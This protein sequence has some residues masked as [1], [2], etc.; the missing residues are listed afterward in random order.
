MA[1]ENNKE[2]Q[3]KPEQSKQEQSK[4]EQSK[5]ERKDS[6]EKS[7]K[8]YL[9]W[10][11]LALI[12]VS[13]AGAGF[14][15]GRLFGRSGADDA[16]TTTQQTEGPQMPP[17]KANPLQKDLTETWYYNFEPVVANLNEPGATRYIRVALT[18]QISKELDP[19]KGTAF[20]EEKIPVLR[21]WLTI[22]L[23]SQTIEDIRGDRNLMRIQS[24]ILD[25]FNEKLFP[26]SKFL[27]K[28]VFFKDF[29]I[30]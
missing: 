29:A 4:P 15:L 24:E 7:K 25:A 23:A 17:V 6:E 22:Y 18:L 13:C 14:G 5:P 1:D 2:E 19:Q 27:I 3:S 9:K 21:N 26:N 11:I 12:S 20:I 28:S 8:G 30:Q 10:I 16:G